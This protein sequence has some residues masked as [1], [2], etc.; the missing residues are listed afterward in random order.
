MPIIPTSARSL[1]VF[2]TMTEPT[3]KAEHHLPKTASD[4]ALVGMIGM[5]SLAFAALFALRR[6]F[7]T[8]Q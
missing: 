8:T 5:L 7:T 2:V 3:T 4:R 6:R 1:P